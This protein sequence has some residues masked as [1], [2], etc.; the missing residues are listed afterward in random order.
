MLLR[1]TF[2]VLAYHI[3]PILLLTAAHPINPAER[4]TGA[5]YGKP[6]II[7][8]NVWIGG[9]AIINPGVTIG[10][11]AVIGSGSVV[12]KN[13]PSNVVV[14]GNPAKVIREIQS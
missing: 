8:S 3:W 4:N 2:S 9:G 12:T 13:V 6:V 7:G 5:E 10:D 14:V 11:N 1:A